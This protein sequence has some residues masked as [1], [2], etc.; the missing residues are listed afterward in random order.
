MRRQ[1]SSITLA[2][3]REKVVY[4]GKE[5]VIRS[6]GAKVKFAKSEFSQNLLENG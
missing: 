1:Q 2:S 5:V 4:L 6:D 3:Y